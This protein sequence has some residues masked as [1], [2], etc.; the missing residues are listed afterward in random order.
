MPSHKAD[1]PAKTSKAA[2]KEELNAD[3]LE[4]V[5]G[6]LKK[7]IGVSRPKAGLSADPCEGGE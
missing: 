7:N 1:A 5:V 2:N 4:K 6:G 3:E